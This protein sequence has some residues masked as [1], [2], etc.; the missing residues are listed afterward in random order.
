MNVGQTGRRCRVNRVVR[1]VAAISR[2]VTHCQCYVI[3][4]LQ[5]FL[6]LGWSLIVPIFLSHLQ[7]LRHRRIE[8]PRTIQVP[9]QAVPCS[10]FRG[11]LHIGKRQ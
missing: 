11:S 8:Q 9:T 2:A 6:V 5:R 3:C 7:C 1:G 4:S 10:Q